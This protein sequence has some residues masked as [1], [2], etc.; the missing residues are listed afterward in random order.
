MRN[1]RFLKIVFAIVIYTFSIAA[2]AANATPQGT[3]LSIDDVTGKPRS[4][5]LVSEKGGVFTGTILKVYPFPG[6]TG[7]C[8]KC[9]G[10]F[11][12][13]P[14]KGLTILWGV[15]KMGNNEWGGGRILDPKSGNIYHVK[16]SLE[17][18]NRLRVR[19]YVGVS[20]LGRTQIWRRA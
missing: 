11:K 8:R 18:S 5:I 3:W 10:N 4:L 1:F 13:K 6:D 2:Y 9:P 15:K 20:V 16:L 17:G 19:G 14:I 7:F 12:N